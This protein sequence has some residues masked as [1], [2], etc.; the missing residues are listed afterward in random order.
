M[1]SFLQIFKFGDLYAFFTFPATPQTNPIS[2]LFVLRLQKN[3]LNN[4]NYE[5]LYF[6]IFFSHPHLTSSLFGPDILFST[7]SEPFPIYVIPLMRGNTLDLC[8]GCIVE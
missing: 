1:V 5:T 7:F 6:A 8:H 2:T 3:L 4:L